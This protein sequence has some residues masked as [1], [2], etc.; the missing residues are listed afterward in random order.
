MTALHALQLSLIAVAMSLLVLSLLFNRAARRVRSGQIDQPQD[1]D[2]GDRLVF[3]I[4]DLFSRESA[5]EML[6]PGSG[7]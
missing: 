6:W 3:W 5:R 2:R 4:D 7:K 1:L